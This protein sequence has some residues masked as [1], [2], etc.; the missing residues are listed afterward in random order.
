[1]AIDVRPVPVLPRIRALC[2][3]LYRAFPRLLI[4]AI[5]GYVCAEKDDLRR[6][7]PPGR[8]RVLI[9]CADRKG[10]RLSQDIE[11]A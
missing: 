5:M 4:G 8:A 10:R 7:A 3:P 9:Y 6:N 1:M 2:S 11:P